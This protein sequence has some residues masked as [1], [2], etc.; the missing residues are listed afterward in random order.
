MM[1]D[2]WEHLIRSV[3]SSLEQMIYRNSIHGGTTMYERD[4]LFEV[5]GYDES[6]WTGEEFD[7]HLLLLSKG[8]EPGY[9]DKV[10]YRYRLHEHNKSMDMSVRDKM[11]RRDWITEHIKNRYV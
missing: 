10:V 9:V 7:L 4:L 3:P 1:D 8:Y 2:G 11:R 5:G 6:L